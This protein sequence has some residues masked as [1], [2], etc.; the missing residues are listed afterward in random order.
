MVYNF[1]KKNAIL[2]GITCNIAVGLKCLYSYGQG[3]VLKN[4][5]IK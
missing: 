2:G 3:S 5:K 1:E 4:T